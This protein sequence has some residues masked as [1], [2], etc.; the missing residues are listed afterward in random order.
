[1]NLGKFRADLYTGM[2]QHL[3]THRGIPWEME[4]TLA[5]AFLF[6]SPSVSKTD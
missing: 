4:Q 2:M 1:M 3:S 5:H 6:K